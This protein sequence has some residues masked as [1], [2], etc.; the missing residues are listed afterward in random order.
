MVNESTLTEPCINTSAILWAAIAAVAV[1]I[2]VAMQIHFRLSLILAF[3]FAIMARE[4]TVGMVAMM[5]AIF[6]LI[7]YLINF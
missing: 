3:L 5:G 7:L 6:V 2:M 1:F 4:H